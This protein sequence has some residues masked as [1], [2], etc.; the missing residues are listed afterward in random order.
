MS[1]H[2]DALLIEKGIDG[3]EVL[4]LTPAREGTAVKIVSDIDEVQV[5]LEAGFTVGEAVLPR[6]RPKR[7][8]QLSFF[9]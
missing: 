7:A 2:S 4:L 3:G 9:E 5:L 8:E 1:T 6:T